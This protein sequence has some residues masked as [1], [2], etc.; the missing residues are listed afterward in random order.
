[1][2]P[3]WPKVTWATDHRSYLIVGAHPCR[4]PSY[5]APTWAPTLRQAARH[6][7]A[8]GVLADSGFDSEANHRLARDD[9]GI[10][11]TVIALN[12]RGHPKAVAKGRYRRQMQCRFPLR[13]YGQ[14]W[15]VES[16]VSQHKRRFGSALRSRSAAAQAR[17]CILRVLL[18]N[19]AI[20]KR[21][22]RFST[23]HPDP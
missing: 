1:M 17:E 14:R 19:V 6:V 22:R 4:G 5:D 23:E 7:R 16:A 10:P 21:H 9:L 3:D 2:M 13:C 12:H 8:K 20:L 18:H 15:H 11:R